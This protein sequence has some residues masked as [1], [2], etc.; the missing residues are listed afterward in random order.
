VRFAFIPLVLLLAAPVSAQEDLATDDNP[1]AA[2]KA[3]LT[4]ALAAAEVPFQEEQDRDITLRM[5]DRLQASE[6]LFGGLMDF[7]GGPTSGQQAERLQSAIGWLRNEF[8]TRVNDYLTPDQLSVWNG[9]RSSADATAGSGIE[10]PATQRPQQTQY[11]RINNNRFTAEDVQFQGGGGTFQGNFGGNFN[12]NFNGGNNRG[13]QGTEVIERGG[14][15]AWH[16]TTQG[17]FKDDALNA[18]NVFAANKPPYQ[19]RQ[20]NVDVG[21]P[22]V[23][24]RLT[25]NMIVQYSLAQNV[26]TI[27]ATLPEGPFALG[28]TRPTT[29][30]SI[31]SRNTLQ[32]ANAFHRPQRAV[33]HRRSQG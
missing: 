9:Y 5:E 21:G 23:P 24:G 32:L 29:N 7:R 16:G 18:R 11:V 3:D 28:I 2:L 14:A 19:E 26:D 27:N 15:G 22:A 33:L 31:E 1:L 8:L 30:R 25:T 17:L 20:V 4:R 12:P 6:A 13:N 10:T